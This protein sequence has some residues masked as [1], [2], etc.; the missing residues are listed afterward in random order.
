MSN[1]EV[2]PASATPEHLRR[3]HKWFVSEWGQEGAFDLDDSTEPRPLVAISDEGT[4][5]GLAFAIFRAPG[6]ESPGIWINALFVAPNHRRK[7]IAT[8]LIRAAEGEAERLGERELY[9]LTDIPELYEK[10]GWRCVQSDST[11]TVVA[12]TIAK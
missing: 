10:L 5:G 8:L 7:G 2:L 6:T 12:K 11:G 1:L 3:L 9:A 4:L